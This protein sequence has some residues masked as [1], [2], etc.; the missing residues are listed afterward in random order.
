MVT[1]KSLIYLL[2]RFI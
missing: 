1:V 2:T